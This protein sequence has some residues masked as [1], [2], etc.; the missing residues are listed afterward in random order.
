MAS[1]LYCILLIPC[2]FARLFF[3]SMGL[4][5]RVVDYA[6][7]YVWITAVFTYF[8][9]VGEVYLIYGQ[10]QEVTWITFVA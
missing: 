10:Y 7:Q 5:E 2:A 1:I 6:S 8:Q 4:D 9:Y 3:E